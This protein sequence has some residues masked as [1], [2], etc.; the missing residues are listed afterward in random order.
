M[1]E[2]LNIGTMVHWMNDQDI[3]ATGKVVEVRTE[4]STIDS[5][6]T[7]PCVIVVV[8]DNGCESNWAFPL[9]EIAI[10]SL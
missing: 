8:S 10:A 4:S 9:N 6:L 2:N 1:R 3:I 7:E 5:T